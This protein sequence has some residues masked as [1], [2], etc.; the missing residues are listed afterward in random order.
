MLSGMNSNPL[1]SASVDGP[2]ID[3]V[4]RFSAHGIMT[5]RVS[6]MQ[7]ARGGLACSLGED[8]LRRRAELFSCSFTFG[9][10]HVLTGKATVTK[11]R[12][13]GRSEGS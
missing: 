13:R 7:S 8:C 10:K 11:P 9:D 5:S 12:L 4:T 1:G 3:H 2:D 6:L